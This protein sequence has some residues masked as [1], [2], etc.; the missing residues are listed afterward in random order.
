MAG[1]LLPLPRSPPD[2]PPPDS[3]LS[4]ALGWTR[5][6]NTLGTYSAFASGGSGIRL[7]KVMRNRWGK[8]VPKAA[9]STAPDPDPAATPPP[10]APPPA[11]APA[12]PWWDLPDLTGGGWYTDRH[13]GQYALAVS[14]PIS[15]RIPTGRTG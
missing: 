11:P 5:K 4:N 1:L 9:P 13:R 7:L 6:P 14:A 8:V 10:P 3:C 2:A 12:P 15:S